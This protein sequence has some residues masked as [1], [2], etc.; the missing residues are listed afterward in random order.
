MLESPGHYFP[1]LVLNQNPPL[2]VCHCQSSDTQS[3]HLWNHEDA[4]AIFSTQGVSRKPTGVTW[5]RICIALPSIPSTFHFKMLRNTRKQDIQDVEYSVLLR[6]KRIREREGEE[7]WIFLSVSGK[8]LL[9]CS[10]ITYNLATLS[11]GKC[12]H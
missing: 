3:S 2:P 4:T 11:T 6:K 8:M 7:S 9:Q 10:Y 5:H 1:W 12:F